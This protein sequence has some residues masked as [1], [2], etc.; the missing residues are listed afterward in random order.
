V[1]SPLGAE[2]VAIGVSGGAGR[3][4]RAVV[5]WGVLAAAG[6]LLTLAVAPATGRRSSVARPSFFVNSAVTMQ[7]IIVVTP[8][9]GQLKIGS[10]V[11]T[12]SFTPHNVYPAV[13]HFNNTI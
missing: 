12:F 10:R 8:G 6:A 9:A 13:V 2:R 4:R 7:P 3:V 5:R 11:F 1:T